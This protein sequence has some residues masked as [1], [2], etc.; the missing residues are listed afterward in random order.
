MAVTSNKSINLSQTGLLYNPQLQDD[1]I[2]EKLFVVRQK[3]FE[4]L[5]N[6]ILKENE[7]SIPQHHLII[8]QRGMGKTTLLKRMEVE[9]HKPQYRQRF[10]PLLFREEQYN[11]KDLAEF[12][13]NTLDAMADSLQ[14]EKYP[15]QMVEDIDKTIREL[16]R[17]PSKIISEEA[18]KY[19]LDICNKLRRRPVLLIDNIGLIFNRLDNK[20]KNNSEQWTLRKLL[21]ENGA[22][23]V[24]CGGIT[25]TDNFNIYGMP[26]FDFF[27]IQ[28]LYKLD[29]D[30]FTKLLIN[31][32]TVTNSDKMIIDSI[33]KNSS[34]QKSLLKLTGGSPRLAVMLFEQIAKGFSSNINDDLEVLA[35]KITPL[36]KARFEELPIQ[37]QIILDTIALNWDAISLKKLSLATHMQNNQLSPQLKRLVDDGWIE[38]TPAYKA[39]GNAYFISE[40]FFN[41][42]YLIRNSSRRHKDKVSCLSKFLDCFYGEEDLRKISDALLKQDISSSEQMCLYLAVSMAKA[43]NFN[44]RKKMQEKAFETLLK[45]KE[46]CD[47]FDIF[48][49]NYITEGIN[50]FNSKQYS[51]AIIYLNKAIDINK[52]DKCA[53]CIKI[54]SLRELNKLKDALICSDELINIIPKEA[55]AWI[56]KGD[57]LYDMKQ[58]DDALLCFNRALEIDNKKDLAWNR[59]GE[60]LF[61]QKKYN[62][63]IKCYDIAIKLNSENLCIRCNKAF[64]LMAQECFEEAI[65]CFSDNIEADCKC[66]TYFS[67]KSNC[68]IN[69]GQY[70]EAVVCLNKAIE[71]TPK[72]DKLWQMKGF[73]LLLIKHYEEAIDCYKE[74]IKLNKKNEY[75]WFL[76]GNCLSD[77]RQYEEAI[78]CYDEALKINP[79]ISIFWSQKGNTLIDLFFY[80]EAVDCINKAIEL[81]PEYFVAWSNKGYALIELQEE[82]AAIDAYKK[83]IE[84]DP[85]DLSSKFN[86]IFLYRD[87]KGEMNKAVQLFDSI[88]ENI[89]KKIENKNFICRY[90]LHKTLFELYKKNKGLASEYLL[91]AFEILDKEE[92]VSSIANTYWWIRFG[93]V[94]IKLGC[95]LWF[96]SFL[97]EKGY[98]IILSPYYT[99]IQALEIEKQDKKNGRENAE[100]YL[101]N[102]AVEISDPAKT[103]VEKMKK[104]ML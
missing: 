42:Y 23:I 93:S 26:F 7:N 70:E 76:E 2:V 59:K 73:A 66:E 41:I 55:C 91:K 69:M 17:K 49:N 11:V 39:K 60:I 75:A 78:V 28:H 3:Q 15:V 38:T 65:S 97:E 4:L 51:D 95:G 96:I 90:Y 92:R 68:L 89:I 101:N 16:S 32:A 5:L 52:N 57:V 104:Y 10:I 22:P 54:K 99:A 40:R 80:K 50:L 47:E 74:A 34:R 13:L 9:L 82:K 1:E 94:V 45:N 58:F 6:K 43:L 72:N 8:G 81:D 29:Y 63:A 71:L 19:L 56:L 31:L 64:A 53:W 62:D 44:Q 30:E 46:L 25:L 84:L 88:D 100:I 27:Q 35:D 12:W 21:S 83:A 18:Q 67:M 37:Q 85:T 48:G 103:I 102:R 61:K 33:Q 86:L 98:N 79:D 14:L 36:Y 24:I 20:N 87:K 77:M